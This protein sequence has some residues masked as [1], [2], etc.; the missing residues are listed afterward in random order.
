MPVK[1]GIQTPPSY[2]PPKR[3]KGIPAFAGMT[4]FFATEDKSSQSRDMRGFLCVLGV[5]CG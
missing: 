1:T 5:L 2:L 3:G 4:V